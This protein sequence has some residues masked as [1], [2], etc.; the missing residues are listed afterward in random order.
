MRTTGTFR[1]AAI[2]LLLLSGA[3]LNAQFTLSTNFTG[4]TTGGNGGNTFD[5]TLLGSP[6]A[7]T[8]FDVKM[9]VTTQQTVDVYFKTGTAAGFATTP[10]AWTLHESVV[11]TGLG[12]ATPTPLNLTTPLLL[13]SG[14]YGIA[15]IAQTTALQYNTYTAP[16]PGYQD[17][18][19]RLDPQAQV[20]TGFLSSINLREW[21][22]VVHYS[23]AGGNGVA[24]GNQSVASSIINGSVTDLT[25]INTTTTAFG[26][27]QT[28]N[29]VTFT[30]SGTVPN[31][32]IGT[33]KLVHDINNDGQLDGGD[34]VLGQG[35]L[36]GST[37]T[38]NSGAGF[39]IPV[40][41][42]GGPR[43]LLTVSS[44]APWVIGDNIEFSIAASTDIVW[45]GGTDFT[46]Y[47]LSSGVRNITPPVITLGNATGAGNAIVFNSTYYRSMTVYSATE[48]ASIPAGSRITEIALYGSTVAAPTSFDN[49]EM[50]LAHSTTLPTGLSTTWTLNYIGTQTA[51]I[52][53]DRYTPEAVPGPTSGS[54]YRFRFDR[55][56]IYNG[57]DG[58]NLDMQ[59]TAR[60]NPG[61]LSFSDTARSRLYTTSPIPAATGT[62]STT[63]GNF[64]LNMYFEA[65]PSANQAWVA[66]HHIP[67][68][69]F[70]NGPI[71]N[72]V[73]L[74][75]DAETLGTS[76]NLG[77]LTFTKTGTV[78]DASISDVR[79]VLDVNADGAID[80]GDTVIGFGTLTAGSISFPFVPALAI[81]PGT[82]Q[83]FLLAFSTSVPLVANDT[84]G[85]QIASS[86]GTSF[87]GGQDVSAYPMGSEATVTGTHVRIGG[88][89]GTTAN[90][91]PFNATTAYRHLTVYS[92][93]ELKDIPAGSLINEIRVFGSTATT[94]T[95]PDFTLRIAHSDANPFS[96]SSTFDANWTGGQSTVIS[97]ASFTPTNAG[98]V[99]TSTI[100]S[101][102]FNAPFLYNGMQGLAVEF[103]WT[104]APTGT[105]FNIMYSAGRQRV[106][107]T[108][109]ASATG[110]LSTSTGAFGVEI[111][112]DPNPNGVVFSSQ[113]AAGPLLAGTMTD[114]ALFDG[115]AGTFGS[116]RTISAMTFTKSGTMPDGLFTNLRLVHDIND[117]GVF[118]GGDVTLGTGTL[119]AGLVSFTIAPPLNVPTTGLQRVL[120]CATTSGAPTLGDTVGFEINAP[121]DIGWSSGP[122]ISGYPIAS[123]LWTV[124]PPELTIGIQGS[125]NA[126][127]F[128][129]NSGTGVG[130]RYQTAYTAAEMSLLPAGSLI[131]EIVVHGSSVAPPTFNNFELRLAHTNVDPA[132][133]SLTWDNYH[134]TLQTVIGP[135]NYLAV[136]LPGVGS[137][138]ARWSFPLTTPFIYN[139]VDGILV[140]WKYDT[141]T[142]VGW[143]VATGAGRNR[144][145]H[146]TLPN[147]PTP[148][149][150][151]TSGNFAIEFHFDPSPDG[152][153][154][155]VNGTIGSGIPPTAT[156][157]VVLDLVA[158]AFT[159][160]R[161]LGAL[162][163]NKLGTAPDA[164]ITNVKLVL[165]N[166]NDGQVDGGDTTLGTGT[167]SSG[168][169]VFPVV[170][171]LSVAVGTPRRLL[172]AAT[173]ASP[174]PFGETFG[175]EIPNAAAISWSGGTD[176]SGYP[177]SSGL[178][179]VR[180]AGIVTIAQTGPADYNDIG[181]AFDALETIG[182]GGP[183]ELRIL[184]SATY[185]ATP[186][187]SLGVSNTAP[188]ARVNVEGVSA[189]NRITLKP[190]P[191]QSPRI[192]GTATGAVLL[193]GVSAGTGRGS[194]VI[195]TSYV[196]IEGLEIFGGPHFGI[197]M[198]GN[199]STHQLSTTDIHILRNKVRDIPF[200]PG[201]IHMGLNSGWATNMVIE[202][203]FV[204]NC[205]SSGLPTSAEL[206]TSSNG[207]ITIRNVP[208]PTTGGTRIRHNTVLHTSTDVNTGAIYMSNSSGAFPLEELSNNI[209]Y[210]TSATVPA[211]FMTVTGHAPVAANTNFNNIFATTVS[212]QAAYN[213]FAAWQLAGYD[214]N[215]IATDP[216]L[217]N[218]TGPAFDLRLTAASPCI[219]PLGQT[220]TTTVDIDGDI[221]PTGFADIG[222][223]ER[224]VME[225]LQGTTVIRSGTTF[226]AG[227]FSTSPTGLTF[228]VRNNSLGA[229]SLTGTPRV[230][231]TLNGNLDPTTVVQTQPAVSVAPAS[232]SNFVVTV[233]PTAGGAF[234]F[235]L[236]ID[237]SSVGQSP[238]VFTVTGIVGP[239]LDLQRP[240]GNTIVNNGTH[241]LAPTVYQFGIS[242]PLTF[243][244]SNQNGG[245]TLNITS[246]NATAGTN[247]T[248][249]TAGAPVSSTVTVGNTTTFGVNFTPTAAGPFSFT[250]NVVSN[251]P[252]DSNYNITV[253]GTANTSPVITVTRTGFGP[254]SNAGVVSVLYNTPLSAQNL[255]IQVT[256]TNSQ[257]TSVAVTISNTTTQGFV[258]SEWNSAS[259]PVPLTRT[260]TSGSFNVPSTTHL[261]TIT[262]DD[263]MNPSVFTFTF[264]VG[265]NTAPT[266]N[267][268]TGSGFAGSAV[269]GYSATVN[270]A[271]LPGNLTLSLFDVDNNLIDVTAV[272]VAPGAP[273][274]IT[275]PGTSVGN[276][277]G[278][279]LTFGGD[280]T[281]TVTGT[282]T[283][284]LTFTDGVAAPVNVDVSITVINFAPVHQASS[285]TQ[286]GDGSA[287]TPYQSQIGLGGLAV[288]EMATVTDANTTQTLSQVS[289]EGNA[290]NPSTMFDVSFN[291]TGA[292]GT[293]DVVATHIATVADVGEHTFTVT[294]TDGF[295]NVA[296][297]VRVIVNSTGNTAPII[298]AAGGSAF[299]GTQVAGFTMS[300]NPGTALANATITVQ[301]TVDNDD[302]EVISVVA[303]SGVPAGITPPTAAS[304]TAGPISLNWGGT[305]LAVNAPGTYGWVITIGDGITMPV[306]FTASITLANIAPEHALPAAPTTIVGNG[307]AATPYEALTEVGKAGPIAMSAVTDQ[308]TGQA[309][310]ISNFVAGVGTPSSAAASG[311]TFALTD[312]NL[313]AIPN[314][315]LKNADTGVHR[316]TVTITDGIAT[317]NIEVAIKVV[318]PKSEPADGSSCTS[319]N[320]NGGWLLVMLA[321]AGL[322]GL[323]VS[324]RKLA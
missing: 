178:G 42:T 27:N 285:G 159:T 136:A 119:T 319:G 160:P 301:D 5:L 167:L 154:I 122:D 111:G 239:D 21:N 270:P 105:G 166:N 15:I 118:D 165:D 192:E 135:T 86:A 296:I 203:N 65:A 256:D 299:T 173:W 286:Q 196:T 84:I 73:M 182:V 262:A 58:I 4:G 176:Y 194:L 130:G 85:F 188:Y 47:P 156:D 68:N 189:T 211:I 141:R 257:N 181:A 70:D 24:L 69:V 93:A 114:R 227:V 180:L 133:M 234:S 123:G 138:P 303:Q 124:V 201:I 94:K 12:S 263:G 205:F 230:A 89:L 187:Y 128:N 147:S 18:F 308:N 253:T 271:T 212:N 283:W 233:D 36:T 162:T 20:T 28:I 16:H 183:V 7:I 222:A 61:W 120:L 168:S 92:A 312:G 304:A 32:S 107:T 38:F 190:A 103:M 104:A 317:T 101:F 129:F 275:A 246:T 202:N 322:A 280:A 268:A 200:G 112:F 169:I 45:S 95:F 213:T 264:D 108:A 80:G 302:I 137:S 217:A 309:L 193:V 279:T 140:D 59:W 208:N 278:T 251:D 177:I 197:M 22:G 115:I 106:Y 289:V 153:A 305:M 14:T 63:G 161:D 87:S 74:E 39:P 210:C 259:A 41:T 216:Q 288:L 226:D 134:G 236:S 290:A 245:Q 48:L 13:T 88:H 171:A 235:T 172:V 229:L 287:A 186:S 97:S 252:L 320:G 204:W 310:S 90:T 44:A 117:N 316:Y 221:R 116:A 313:Y 258:L 292:A 83:Q 37:I 225:V 2:A 249:V 145:Y 144:V 17:T 149:T 243:T 220:S 209:L 254:V 142:S 266:I 215:G 125:G 60:N 300:V 79:L 198:Q 240:A 237:N 67:L 269:A 40:A 224:P 152:V 157:M 175:L 248:T 163:F 127:P 143:T 8:R 307:T 99:G 277:S 272:N 110:T 148:A 146:T 71:A 35:T 11:T 131:T 26:A 132:V 102:P 33:I 284:T 91:I 260:P 82:P 23:P 54:L 276:A 34:T 53:A 155:G 57:T 261:V 293:V 185:V 3:A 75:F 6:V 294:V 282:Y 241:S 247:I 151:T 223:D 267:L 318:Q 126:F 219:D 1:L 51:V 55:P 56:F 297:V 228:A 100:W 113:T 314:A 49:F 274:G 199:S 206:E 19:L 96:M 46:G 10:G 72:K 244:I 62:N 311:F 109:P 76:Q 66:N 81:A 323:A 232:T 191:G 50:R 9:S 291:G 77:A 170:P 150:N 214:T 273:A 242:H 250:V 78:L 29:S 31:A 218:A 30:K 207:S 295:V 98:T 43:L 25:F 324:R 52:S 158:N 321:L 238:Y 231:I 179:T 184:D 265:A 64:G 298:S 195:N 255:N 306:A 315:V 174:L 281:L 121:T 164:S 139:G